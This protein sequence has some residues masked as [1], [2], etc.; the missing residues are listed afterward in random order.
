M[1]NQCW[2]FHRWEK[3]EEVRAT[4]T[5]YSDD[6]KQMVELKCVIQRRRC[7]RCGLHEA[8]ELDGTMLL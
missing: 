5:R 8:R 6:L 3:W 4:K 7:A 2:L 1:K